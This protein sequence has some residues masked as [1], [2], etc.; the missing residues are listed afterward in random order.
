MIINDRGFL[1]HLHR[2]DQPHCIAEVYNTRRPQCLYNYERPRE[3]YNIRNHRNCVIINNL[4]PCII[5]G[6]HWK[7][8]IIKNQGKFIIPDGLKKH[9]WQN[10]LSD[11]SRAPYTKNELDNYSNWCL[12]CWKSFT[13]AQNSIEILL[14]SLYKIQISIAWKT[15][16]KVLNCLR[17]L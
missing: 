2:P 6:H 17:T 4:M 12:F 1:Y 10:W 7:L 3:V 8:V 5:P 15:L 14:C 11:A 9:S 16:S 13:H